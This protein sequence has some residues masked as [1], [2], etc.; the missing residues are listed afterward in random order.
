MTRQHFNLIAEA[1]RV[2]FQP[3]PRYAALIDDMAANLASTNPRFDKE[4]FV[5]ACYPA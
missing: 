1:L 4:R 2:N 3:T 5:L